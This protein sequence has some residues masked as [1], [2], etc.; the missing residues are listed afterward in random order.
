M[1]LAAGFGTRLKPLTDN[2]PKC[3]VPINGRPLLDYWLD[4]LSTSPHVSEIF[5]NTHYLSEQVEKHLND[6]W[7]HLS[8]LTVWYEE[9]LL[10]TGGTIRA[11]IPELADDD[12]MVIHADNLSSFDLKNFIEHHNNRPTHCEMSMMLFRTDTPS[13]CGIVELENNTV[14]AMHEKVVNPPGNLANGAVYIFSPKVIDWLSTTAFC[15]ISNDV[16]PMLLGK[17]TAWTN[18]RY[19]RDIGTPESYTQAQID[20]K[21]LA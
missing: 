16:I 5:I 14:T 9:I 6:H 8:N 11:H 18:T 10:G 17:I 1:L 7:A 20:F 12:V 4:M 15:D 19:H 13:S 21:A 2:T 3:L